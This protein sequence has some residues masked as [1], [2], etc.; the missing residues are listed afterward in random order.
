VAAGDVF[1][2]PLVFSVNPVTKQSTGS[3]MQFVVTANAS[4][5]GSGNLTAI[6]SPAIITA[7]PFQNVTAAR[8]TRRR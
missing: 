4:S 6:I 8:P 3:L 1:T 7:G 2:L 5:D